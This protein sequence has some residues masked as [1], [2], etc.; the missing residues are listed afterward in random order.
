LGYHRDGKRGKRQIVIALLTDIE[1]EPLAV[2]VFAGNTH[3]SLTGADQIAILRQQFGVQEL[4][5]VGDRGMIESKG[6][7]ALHEAGLHYISALTD[8]QI[9]KLLSPGRLPMELFR[10]EVA[11]VEDGHLR[12]LL[13]RNPAEAAREGCRLENKMEKLQHKVARRN[14]QVSASARGQPESGLAAIREWVV[15]QKRFPFVQPRL[16]GR[17]LVID[18]DEPGRARAMLRAGCYV[19]VPDLPAAAMPAQTAHASYVRLQTGERDL[20]TMKTGRLEVRPVF[21]RKETRTRGHVLCTRLALKIARPGERCLQTA[22]GTTD[23]DP[24]AITLPDVLASLG[25]R[26]LL[27]YPLEGGRTVTRLPL[28]NHLQ[29]QILAALRVTLPS[30]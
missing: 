24:R 28:A 5:F 19:I 11:E 16:D 23:T 8:P 3:D 21:V 29:Q 6:K 27:H 13:R 20:R 4:V 10:E 26:C 14:Q 30:T 9:R 25:R 17:L 12:Y 18:V 1:G 7:Q 22:F 15:R 2:R